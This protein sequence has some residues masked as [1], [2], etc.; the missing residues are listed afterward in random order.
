MKRVWLAGPVILALI[1]VAWS[2]LFAVDR[3]EFAYVTQFGKPVATLDGATE[4]G[5]HVKWPWPI[6]SVQR[7]DRR[8][9]MFDLP[10]AELPT[11]DP[12]GQTIDKMLTVDGFA[13]WRIEDKAGADL[14]IRTVGSS[15]RAKAILG[16]RI[17]ARLGAIISQMA[18][19]ELIHV[20]T[21]RPFGLT[22]G[23]LS[24]VLPATS[25]R[26]YVVERRMADLQ[27]RIYGKGDD[28]LRSQL[29]AEY[30]IV[31]VDVRVRRFNYPESVKPAIFARI[32]SE[33]ERKA[34]DYISDGDR[35]AR[36]IR[37]AADRDA[38]ITRS[39]AKAKAELIQKQADAD[40]DRIRSEAFAQD[41]EFYA[42]LQKLE[43]YR[44]MLGKT[45]DTLLLSSKHPLFD[46]M[47]NPPTEPGEKGKNGSS[48]TPENGDKKGETKTKTEPPR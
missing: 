16:P 46:L 41:R 43:A 25:L 45:N 11:Y 40:A 12:Q 3:A 1:Y 15:E 17:G 44:Q 23:G 34:A 19:D 33:R 7:I 32:R 20:P 8:L 48:R 4:A 26:S 22:I 31:L 24:I 6:Q 42:F 27:E 28:S 29:A 21:A 14:F 9:Q 47:L 38:E 35:K 2:S 18:L 10:T 39:T 36:E 30:G 5:L 37:S 13:C